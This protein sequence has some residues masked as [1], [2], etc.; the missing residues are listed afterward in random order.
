MPTDIQIYC[1]YMADFG[2]V[3]AWCAGK[4]AFGSLGA[5]KTEY[6]AAQK[7]FASCWNAKAMLEALVKVNPD[8]YPVPLDP[9]QEVAPG[10]KHF[11]ALLMAL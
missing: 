6:S 10:R 8:F 3:S 11:P 4:I 7:N 2:T 9:P 1:D 5:N